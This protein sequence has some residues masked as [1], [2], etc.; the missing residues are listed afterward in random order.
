MGY[1]ECRFHHRHGPETQD[2]LDPGVRPACDLD[3]LQREIQRAKE[4]FSLPDEARR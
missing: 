1:L 2:A 4:R 3:A